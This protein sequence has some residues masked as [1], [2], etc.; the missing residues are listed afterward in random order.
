MGWDK[1]AQKKPIKYF[2]DNLFHRMNNS[3][4]EINSNRVSTIGKIAKQ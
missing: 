4:L 1:I 3:E 2:H